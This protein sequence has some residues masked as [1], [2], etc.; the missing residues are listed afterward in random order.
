MVDKPVFPVFGSAPNPA[1][2]STF[3]ARATDMLSKLPAFAVAANAYPAYIDGRVTAAEQEVDAEIARLGNVQPELR[4]TQQIKIGGDP[5]YLYPVYWEFPHPSWGIGRMEIHRHY[6][7]NDNVIH[8]SHTADLLVEIEGCGSSWGGP[9]R[10]WKIARYAMGYHD[11]ISHLRFGMFCKTTSNDGNALT[12]PLDYSPRYAGC[13]LR[14]GLTY[15]F[16]TN[17]NVSLNR[18]PDED[19]P[20]SDQV[21][22]WYKNNDY[23]VERMPM[24]EIEQPAETST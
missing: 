14:G 6:S 5:N 1:D 2:P 11:C 16:A 20:S 15:G 23:Y 22:F 10:H 13:Y 18:L 24:S 12:K 9:A 8:A 21:T 19:D 17:W 3:D 4:K 7:W